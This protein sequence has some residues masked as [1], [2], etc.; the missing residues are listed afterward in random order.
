M[1]NTVNLKNWLKRNNSTIE[2]LAKRAGV[3]NV[4]LSRIFNGHC[5]PSYKTL[6]ALSE[7]TN[8]SFNELLKKSA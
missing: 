6:E 3:S 8:L 7:A 1:I 5:E 4:T 2:E